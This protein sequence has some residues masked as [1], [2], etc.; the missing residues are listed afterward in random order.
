MTYAYH[1]CNL[2]PACRVALSCKALLCVKLIF[3]KVLREEQRVAAA[4][5]LPVRPGKHAAST[6]AIAITPVRLFPRL[7]T[8][9]DSMS[10]DTALLSP[11]SQT[12]MVPTAPLGIVELHGL[13]KTCASGGQG[14]WRF[15]GSLSLSTRCIFTQW[16]SHSAVQLPPHAQGARCCSRTFAVSGYSKGRGTGD[17]CWV[18]I[19]M[20]SGLVLG[21]YCDGILD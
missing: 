2:P 1:C 3:F 17:W 15:C 20:Y 12:P 19:V 18:H 7:T 6:G 10:R 13:K 9:S 14:G 11:S 4:P 8:A 21:S 5:P 16:Y